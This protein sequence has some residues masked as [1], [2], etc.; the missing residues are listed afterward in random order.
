MKIVFSILLSAFISVASAQQQI[1]GI[2]GVVGGNV[3][4]ESDIYIQLEQMK[5]QGYPI[6]DGSRCELFENFMFQKLLVQQAELDS[7][8]VSDKEVEDEIN[9]RLQYHLARLNG[10][11]AEFEKNYGSIVEFK[12]LE[13]P[14]IREE[15]LVRQMRSQIISD[16]KITPSEVRQYF[17]R[18]PDDSL[19][20]IAAKYEIA[21]IV[22][23]PQMNQFERERVMKEM[24][25]IRTDI[26]VGGRDFGTMAYLFSEDGSKMNNGELGYISREQVVAEFAAVAFKMKIG[27]VSE[28]FET[29]FGFHILQV[30]EKKGQLLKVRH[31][32]KKPKI[33]N[34]DMSIAK[35]KAD[36]IYKVIQEGK[37]TFGE[38]AAKYSSDQNTKGNG[39]MIINPQTGDSKFTAEDLDPELAA[40]VSVLQK[41]MMTAPQLDVEYG[42]SNVYKVIKLVDYVEA[43]Q[44][45]LNDDFDQIKN[46]ALQ[47]KQQ[48]EMLKWVQKRLEATYSRVSE[49]Y[50]SCEQSKR[51]LTKK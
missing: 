20:V 41:G 37:A 23:K 35:A 4:L 31:I 5:L 47:E 51:W 48:K 8:E 21:E 34:F 25:R 10:S 7:V 19:P 16:I 32:L 11:E 12:Q 42:G 46:A 13:T 45:N 44:A 30:M 38:M 9:R 29:E 17:D 14:I 36:S 27:E 26:T 39:G 33:Y 3:V 22:I 15:L 2:A 50:Q 28:V 6:T 49:N 40:K 1:D 18:M 24:Q 43:H